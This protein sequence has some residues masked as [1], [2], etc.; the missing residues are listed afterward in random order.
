MALAKYLSRVETDFSKPRSQL[1][2]AAI[3]VLP[4]LITI[5]QK[6]TGLALVFFSLF[7]V[8]FREGLPP[9]YLIIGFSWQYW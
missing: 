1:I 4:A 6:E 7:L 9:G 3:V 8:M 5:A 2:A